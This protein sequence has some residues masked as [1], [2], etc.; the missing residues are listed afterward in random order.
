MNEFRSLLALKELRNSQ[1]MSASSSKRINWPLTL[2]RMLILAS[3]FICSPSVLAEGASAGSATAPNKSP[4]DATQTGAFDVREDYRRANK[5][6]IPFGP[7]TKRN[8]E[9]L[10]EVKNRES[11]GP[12][13]VDHGPGPVYIWPVKITSATSKVPTKRDSGITKHRLQ[14]FGL[15]IS[16]TQFQMI[17]RMDQ[18]I[19][20][21]E[22]FDP[23]RVMWLT[24]SMG[25]SQAQ[26]ASNSCANVA[27]NQGASAIDYVAC[28]IYNFTVDDQNKW[29]KI[30]NQLFMPMAVLLLLPGAVLAQVRVIVSSGMP[31]VAGEVNP[32][33]GITRSIVAIFLIPATYLVVN[34]G[35]D[36]NNSITFT[37]A[38][39]YNRIFGSNMYKDALCTV[40]RAFPVRQ[41][42]ENRNGVFKEVKP[43]DKGGKTPAEG[44]E[45]RSLL[46]KMEDPCAGVFETDPDRADEQAPFLSVGQRF[47]TN[48]GNAVLMST[49]NILCAFQVVFLCYLWLVGPVI[50]ALWVYPMAQLRGALG[51]WVEGVITLCFWSL[52]WN[53]A[54]LLF[55]CF[56][57]VD[58]TG[59]IIVS[60]LNFL[61]IQCVKSAFDFAGLVRAAGDKAA[62]QAAGL[63]ASAAGG[64]KPG[65]SAGSSG[66]AHAG[67]GRGHGGSGGGHV[68]SSHG[69]H[70]GSAAHGAVAAGID[71]AHGAGAHAAGLSGTSTSMS[72]SGALVGSSA[73]IDAGR[74]IGGSGGIGS[75]GLDKG[76]LGDKFDVPPGVGGLSAAM[77]SGS[78]IA[79]IAASIS[80]PPMVG[81]GADINTLNSIGVNAAYNFSNSVNSNFNSSVDAIRAGGADAANFAARDINNLSTLIGSQNAANFPPPGQMI[82]D[83][84]AAYRN[85]E[86]AR[87][88]VAKM[89]LN[90]TNPQ[91]AAERNAAINDWRNMLDA[92]ERNDGNGYAQPGGGGYDSIA[93]GGGYNVSGGSVMDAGSAGPLPQG[94][95]IAYG[96]VCNAV[97]NASDAINNLRTSANAE[98][99]Q[100][101]SSLAREMTSVAPTLAGGEPMA[102]NQQ[103]QQW[104]QRAEQ[105]AREVTQ[106]SA[107]P[108]TMESMT[109]AARDVAAA[110][111]ALQTFQN[112]YP[113]V[114]YGGGNVMPPQESYGGGY[115][116]GGYA[117]ESTPY[118]QGG[119]VVYNS[120]AYT[121][122]DPAGSYGNPGTVYQAQQPADPGYAGN[123]ARDSYNYNQG[124]S[125]QDQVSA[126]G[127][128]TG[129]QQ[130]YAQYD[131]SG[132]YGI[133]GQTYQNQS[134]ADPGNYGGNYSGYG[135]NQSAD[136]AYYYQMQQNQAAYQDQNY[137]IQY[138]NSGYNQAYGDPG[139]QQQQYYGQAYPGGDATQYANYQNYADPAQQQYYAQQ[140]Q[141]Y[142]QAQQQYYANGY[143]GGYVDQS[144]NYGYNQGYNNQG[145]AEQG[146]YY[147]NA[148]QG[149]APIEV[150]YPNAQPGSYQDMQNQQYLYAAYNGNQA[151][152]QWGHIAGSGG[153]VE[154]AYQHYNQQH[155]PSA[156]HYD[157]HNQPEQHYSSGGYYGGAYTNRSTGSS[158]SNTSQ[159]KGTDISRL[160][161]RPAEQHQ[162]SQG[163]S[164]TP[165][166]SS[167]SSS[168]SPASPDK[169]AGNLND[170]LLRNKQLAKLS[171]EERLKKKKEEEERKRKQQQQQQDGNMPWD[172][173]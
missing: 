119:G 168:S 17:H 147:N 121:G 110:Q 82:T 173:K 137:G 157:Q 127:G 38:N 2:I 102:I 108:M 116:G 68:G 130:Q 166:T 8:P 112:N 49:W 80:N 66:G 156:P 59:S 158:Q 150:P 91:L 155:D 73:G 57:G 14:T 159:P 125:L 6:S 138:N 117:R 141:Y 103:M 126:A 43:W 47:V 29:N 88:D 71:A 75:G 171:E 36:L 154:Q 90:E 37:I 24:A 111:S 86:Q 98:A 41:A 51:G 172:N 10:D 74:G 109:T 20:L 105:L 53:T 28:S 170:E 23:E 3:L 12:S 144:N 134:A 78:D 132:T 149:G 50:A 77:A 146:Y 11:Q 44:M 70:G 165:S 46:T 162:K 18:Q 95:N 42:H 136:A 76:G 5:L 64:V 31:I 123:Y 120:N 1:I 32:F 153:H 113:Q 56:R 27:R 140:Q 145:Y 163:A 107:T 13:T 34:Y 45:S 30:R 133:Q 148:S 84:E 106:P 63:G 164:S 54:V 62:G 118:A 151:G 35:I 93:A 131:N 139:Y 161:Q 85:F 79:G 26:D 152:E 65:S 58:S 122:S 114:A 167:T 128:S 94:M 33:E 97:Q 104:S 4:N 143:Q 55:A 60:A 7:P 135:T 72:I 39:E 124:G 69:G 15:P 99:V 96:N 25:T 21:E 142:D 81:G 169:K 89:N 83:K 19:M 160:S 92:G 22:M 9:G 101:I 40:I 67:G 100:G 16:D 129:Y 52:F 87:M 61:A 48:G 115:S